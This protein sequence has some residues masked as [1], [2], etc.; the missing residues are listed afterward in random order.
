MPTIKNVWPFPVDLQM[1]ALERQALRLGYLPGYCCVCGK[2][3]RFRVD[4]DF[5]ES[6][7]C[8]RCKSVNRQ[9]QLVTVLLEYARTNSTRERWLS[10]RDIAKDTTIW[11]AESTRALHFRL[12]H[13]LGPNY[14]S[15]EYI[16]P[17]LSSGDV[18]EGVLHV[19]MR[20]THF[21]DESL[22]FVLSSEVLEHVPNPLEAFR[23]SF[24]IL[25]PGGCHIFTVPFYQHRFTNEKRAVVNEFGELTY[26]LR[27]WYHVDLLHGEGALVYNVFGPELMCQLEEIGFEAR[28]CILRAPFRGILGSNGIVMVAQKVVEPNHR[29]DGIF[30][31]DQDWVRQESSTSTDC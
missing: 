16:R 27:P 31:D 9:R 13:H 1:T 23:E 21:D 10:V 7:P 11:N 20:R 24:R 17:D 19:D 18:Q 3:T 26:L 15:S 4:A 6:V 5:R 22:D 14:I 29:R 30:A 25:K 12:A 28:L 8:L 2:I